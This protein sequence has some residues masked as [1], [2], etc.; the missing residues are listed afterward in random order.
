MTNPQRFLNLLVIRFIM[1]YSKMNISIHPT[2]RLILPI[3]LFIE[4]YL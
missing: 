4:N 1:A 2:L 3:Y